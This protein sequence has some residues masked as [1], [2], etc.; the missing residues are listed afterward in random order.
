MM[1]GKS[2][3]G[4]WVVKI[5]VLGRGAVPWRQR[6]GLETTLTEAWLDDLVSQTSRSNNGEVVGCGK[7]STIVAEQEER[8]RKG[9]EAAEM[10]WTIR[11]S[12]HTY[13]GGSAQDISRSET[14][15]TQEG[16]EGQSQQGGAWLAA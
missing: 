13:R 16:Y 12:G 3:S 6:P 4:P 10:D 8:S 15:D 14:N 9:R 7:D 11:E 5:V 2:H 1:P